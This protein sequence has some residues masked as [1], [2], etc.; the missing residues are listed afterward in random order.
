VIFQIKEDFLVEIGNE[1]SLDTFKQSSSV[2]IKSFESYSVQYE[3]LKLFC[4]WNKKFQF[5]F[6]Y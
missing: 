1:K 2:E 3:Y 5:A 6:D 4:K